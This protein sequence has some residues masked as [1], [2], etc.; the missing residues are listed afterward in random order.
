MSKSIK[1][2]MP[3]YI[4]DFFTATACMSG[5]EAGAYVTILAHLWQSG[6]SIPANDKKL[7][8]LCKATAKEWAAIK[9]AVLP[10][11]DVQDGVLTHAGTTAEL[12]KA[13]ANIEQ[14]QRAGKASA[15]ARLRL[16][17]GQRAFNGRSTGEP[18]AGQPCAGEGEGA[19]PIQRGCLGSSEGEAVIFR[20]GG[21]A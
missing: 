16:V 17:S 2:W 8:Q 10:L 6:G 21:A 11:F 5:H 12:A 9:Q 7:A 14:K 18:T 1:I 3:V 20:A 15:D 13:Q 4:G 19:G